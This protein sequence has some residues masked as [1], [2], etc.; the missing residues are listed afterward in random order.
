MSWELKELSFYKDNCKKLRKRPRN[1]YFKGQ[2]LIKY[3][4]FGIYKPS[5]ENEN[6]FAKNRLQIF[7]VG[8]KII[9]LNKLINKPTSIF[10]DV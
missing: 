9:R 8:L 2:D 5:R 4:L 6:N 10:T 3:T 7:A 1:E